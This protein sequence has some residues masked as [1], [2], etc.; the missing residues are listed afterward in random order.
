MNKIVALKVE[1]NGGIVRAYPA[2]ETAQYFCDLLQYKS[3][4]KRALEIISK[5]GFE[6]QI[7]EQEIKPLTVEDIS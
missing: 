2:N 3:L 7:V 5:L 1:R 4:S 6:I